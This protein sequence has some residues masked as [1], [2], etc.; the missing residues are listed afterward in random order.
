MATSNQ[1]GPMGYQCCTYMLWV[2]AEGSLCTIAKL[3][4]NTNIRG[5]ASCE[6]DRNNLQRDAD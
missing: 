2:N 3:S 5:K 4:D 1:Q 6:E